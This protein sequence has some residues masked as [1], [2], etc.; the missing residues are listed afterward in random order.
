MAVNPLS[1]YANNLDPHVKKRYCEKISC[2]G[3]DPSLIPDKTYDPDCLPRVESM[4]LLSLLVLGT[5][6][7]S[8]DQFKAFWSLQAYNQLVSGFVSCLKGNKI[9]YNYIV[10][11]KVRHSQRMNDPCVTLWIITEENGTVL[12]AHCIGSM[13]GQGECCSHIASVLFY[14]EAWNRVNEKL[15]CT[16]VKCSWLMPT[17]VKEVPYAPVSRY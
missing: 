2:V 11:G 4:D 9:G 12:F 7:Y 13:A 17:A 15:S 10:L 5:S 16:Q 6:Y 1:N 14:I 8:K 3:I